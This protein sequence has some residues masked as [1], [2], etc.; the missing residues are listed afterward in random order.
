MFDRA[1]ENRVLRLFAY[2]ALAAASLGH[3]LRLDDLVGRER[4]VAKVKDLSLVRQIA[5]CRQRLVDVSIPV[6]AVDL[7]EIDVIRAKAPER[8]LN[9]LTDPKAR[10][11][12]SVFLAL[13]IIEEL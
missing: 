10:A 8:I 13:E 2:K 7:V 4:R 12:T 3:P 1:G 5:Q 6:I 11:A 9:R